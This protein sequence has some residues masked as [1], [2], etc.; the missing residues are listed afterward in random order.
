[1]H[2]GIFLIGQIQDPTKGYLD[3]SNSSGKIGEE[4]GGSDDVCLSY[5]LSRPP[6]IPSQSLQVSFDCV[7]WI[8]V[9]ETGNPGTPDQ[10]W[11]H[12]ELRAKQSRFNKEAN[13]HHRHRSY[14]IYKRLSMTCHVKLLLAR[15]KKQSKDAPESVSNLITDTKVDVYLAYMRRLRDA[16]VTG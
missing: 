11:V 7:E 1:M 2:K 9:T 13:K 14:I 15:D 3:P 10:V 6:L 16:C 8:S 4:G 5:L 12:N